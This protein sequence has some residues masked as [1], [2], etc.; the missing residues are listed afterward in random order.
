MTTDPGHPRNGTCRFPPQRAGARAVRRTILI[1][2]L[3]TSEG[4]RDVR[5]ASL[6]SFGNTAGEACSSIGPRRVCDISMH[7]SEL[8]SCFQA[9]DDHDWNRHKS[10]P[11]TA[12]RHNSL[13]ANKLRLDDGFFGIEL[14]ERPIY[15][16]TASPDVDRMSEHN[17]T[18]IPGRDTER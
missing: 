14:V 2:L 16:I 8:V 7:R 1:L 10:P 11:R 4:H 15:L 13:S 6:S 9:H 3:D 18:T 12:T 5:T 17:F